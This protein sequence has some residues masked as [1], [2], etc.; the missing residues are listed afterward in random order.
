MFTIAL[1]TS[2]PSTTPGDAA[3]DQ[4][5]PIAR[6]T[7]TS[8]ATDSSI[9]A[10]TAPPAANPDQRADTHPASAARNGSALL[11]D[12]RTPSEAAGGGSSAPAITVTSPVAVRPR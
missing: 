1:F 12:R 7:A 9:P 8:I 3:A 4:R 10:A 2:V 5:T 6:S 11:R